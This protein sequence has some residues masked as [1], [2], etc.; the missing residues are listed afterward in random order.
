[1]GNEIPKPSPSHKIQITER[2][3]CIEEKTQGY[4]SASNHLDQRL[5]YVGAAYLWIINPLKIS[6][7]A[8]PFVGV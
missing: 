2:S 3:L 4:H 5:R 7:T 8:S 1:M 6:W